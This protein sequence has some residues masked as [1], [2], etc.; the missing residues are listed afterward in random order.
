MQAALEKELAETEAAATAAKRAT[1]GEDHEMAG[2]DDLATKDDDA[3]EAES[4][5]LEADSSGS[6]EEDEDEEGAEGAEGA[7]GDEDMEMA[8]GDEKP[9]GNVKAGEQKPM[10]QQGQAQVM[11]H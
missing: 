11:V 8:E 3:S 7:E 5:D 1:N 10:P 6:D 4:E 2:T 9:T